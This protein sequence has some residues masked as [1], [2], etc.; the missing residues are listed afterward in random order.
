M[1]VSGSSWTN[2]STVLL[3]LHFLQTSRLHY[4][5]A[6]ALTHPIFDTHTHTHRLPAS[7]PKALLALSFGSSNFAKPADTGCEPPNCPRANHPALPCI[8]PTDATEDILPLPNLEQRLE[9]QATF[10]TVVAD[11]GKTY[12]QASRAVKEERSEE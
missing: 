9:P 2:Y 3:H 5:T 1:C 8:A 4:Y 10:A 11:D 12:F 7:P 6:L